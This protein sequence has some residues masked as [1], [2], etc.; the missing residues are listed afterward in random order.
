MAMKLGASGAGMVM[1]A[2]STPLL[3]FTNRMSPQLVT[4][5]LHILCCDVPY[6]GSI[7]FSTQTTSASCLSGDETTLNAESVGPTSAKI[8]SRGAPSTFAFADH[9]L[10]GFAPL[11]FTSS[12]DW[13]AISPSGSGISTAANRGR[14]SA[15]SLPPSNSAT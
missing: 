13:T 5:Q 15:G 14:K 12:T 4:E 1:W 2:S 7:I 9:A 8:S 10:L 11:I 6:G 3:V